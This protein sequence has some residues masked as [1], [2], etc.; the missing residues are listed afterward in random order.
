MEEK[1]ENY[2]N[3][4][5]FGSEFIAV[6]SILIKLWDLSY[7]IESVQIGLYIWVIN[8]LVDAQS[9]WSQRQRISAIE[10]NSASHR[11]EQG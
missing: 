8:K 4:L 3:T 1:L 9:T 10:K 6:L 2:I 11:G 7:A 5:Q